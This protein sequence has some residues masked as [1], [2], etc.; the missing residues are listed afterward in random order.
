MRGKF[1][2]ISSLVVGAVLVLGACGGGSSKSDAGS[3]STPTTAK[4]GESVSTGRD[5]HVLEPAGAN[6]SQSA[7]MVCETEAI[8]DIAEVLG[9]KSTQ[10]S[11]PTWND[12]V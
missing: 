3:S 9:A 10:P 4:G 8:N 6:P 2:S 11:P 7:K 1:L 5:G 12:H